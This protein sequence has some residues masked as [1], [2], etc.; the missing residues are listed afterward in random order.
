MHYA[1]KN[2]ETINTYPQEREA[3]LF[4][5]NKGALIREEQGS[6]HLHGRMYFSQEKKG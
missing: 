2:R 4:E 3:Y 5:R 6:T 1:C